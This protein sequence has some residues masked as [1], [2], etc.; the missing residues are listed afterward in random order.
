MKKFLLSLILNMKNI[1]IFDSEM[2][3][4]GPSSRIKIN[5]FIEKDIENLQYLFVYLL[6]VISIYMYMIFFIL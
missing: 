5:F 4:S 1:K 6:I 3:P 2:C